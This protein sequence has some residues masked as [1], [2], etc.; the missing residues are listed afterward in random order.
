MTESSRGLISPS[1]AFE[2]KKMNNID[3]FSKVNFFHRKNI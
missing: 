3:E 1:I 2:P